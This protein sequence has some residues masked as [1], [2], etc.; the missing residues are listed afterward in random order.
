MSLVDLR[1]AV[2]TAIQTALPSLKEV[3]AHGGRFSLE[4]LKAASAR[5]PS[6]RVACLGF[7]DIAS[8]EVGVKAQTVWGAFVIAGDQAQAHRDA[9]ALTIVSALALLVP[10]NCWGLDATVDQAR[11]VRA[12]NL[13]SRD[14]DKN[15]VALWAV[16]WR[17]EVDIAGSDLTELN[18]F[19][20]CHVDYDI[21]QDGGV[22]LS[23]EIE[24]PQ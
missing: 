17:Q 2:I 18:D 8:T 15:G 13:F 7:S 9:L 11:Q 3:K 5:A 12:D 4:E 21:N 16:T 10:G 22:D 23:D 20:L 6:V 24:L 1:T 14:L 19:V